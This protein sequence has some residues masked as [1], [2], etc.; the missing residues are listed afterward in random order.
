MSVLFINLPGIDYNASKSAVLNTLQS[1]LV[2][3]Q[4]EIYFWRVLLDN[5]LWMTKEQR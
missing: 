2:I 1:S 4:E 5:L 3:M